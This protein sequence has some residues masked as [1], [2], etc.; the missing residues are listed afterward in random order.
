M[1]SDCPTQ[2][3][4]KITT[5]KSHTAHPQ[6]IHIILIEVLSWLLGANMEESSP[7]LHSIFTVAGSCSSHT[8]VVATSLCLVMLGHVTGTCSMDWVLWNIASNA[9]FSVCQTRHCELHHGGSRLLYIPMGNAV[10]PWCRRLELGS[11]PEHC[12]S[13]WMEFLAICG[14]CWSGHHYYSIITS[15]GTTHTS[16]HFQQCVLLSTSSGH[17]VKGCN[18][19]WIKALD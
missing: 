14:W 8:P 11:H 4:G 3:N 6:G 9:I 10:L 12:S 7:T 2:H 1:E 15:M 13:W 19:T 17:I 18:N 16:T 5:G